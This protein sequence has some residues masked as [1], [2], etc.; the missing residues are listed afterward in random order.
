M[1]AWNDYLAILVLKALP[2]NG[3]QNLEVQLYRVSCKPSFLLQVGCPCSVYA[4]L[5]F[6]K[7]SQEGMLLTQDSDYFTR[8]LLIN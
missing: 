2:V 7:F 8:A 6:F 5:T 3:Q 1:D 4:Y